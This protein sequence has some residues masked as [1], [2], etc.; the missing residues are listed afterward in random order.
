M[1][2]CAAGGSLTC[3]AFASSILQMN[4]LAEC[5]A[6]E[7]CERQGICCLID[8]VSIWIAFLVVHQVF[9]NAPDCRLGG[10]AVIQLLILHC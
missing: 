2:S 8:A 6:S 4:S 9:I 7:S 10:A 1:R 3:T 5:L